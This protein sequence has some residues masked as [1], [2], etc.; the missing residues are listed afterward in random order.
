MRELY[1]NT[2]VLILTVMSTLH[3]LLDNFYLV[4]IA[5]CPFFIMGNIYL[6]V[7]KMSE[8][9]KMLLLLPGPLTP[10]KVAGLGPFQGWL[11]MNNFRQ[12]SSYRFGSIE[13]VTFKQE[14]AQRFFSVYFHNRI[15]FSLETYF[16][17][18]DCTCLDTSMSGS[19]GMFPTRPNQ[20][21]QSFPGATLDD[22]CLRHLEAEE[23]LIK[24]FNLRWKPLTLPYEE[25]LLK[26]IRLRM[27]FVRSIPLYPIRALYWYA[28]TRKKVANRSIQQQFPEVYNH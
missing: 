25:I 4:I 15:T 10:R 23:Y 18:V 12:I 26:A 3:F 5:A 22:L 13:T 2:G 21:Q 28:I 6:L 17:D 16:D 9:E 7:R 14:G 11:Q 19:S 20:Y 1:K 8:P 24:K 27:Q